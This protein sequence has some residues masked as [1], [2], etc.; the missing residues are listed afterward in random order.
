MTQRGGSAWALNAPSM[1]DGRALG[2]ADS[3]LSGCQMVRTKV[4]ICF[5]AIEIGLDCVPSRCLPDCV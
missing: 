3:S 1:F 4:I 2:E 5:K